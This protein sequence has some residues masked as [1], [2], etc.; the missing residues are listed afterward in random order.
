M[1][2]VQLVASA[3]VVLLG[4]AVA[5][6]FGEPGYVVIVMLFSLPVAAIQAP[7][8]IVLTRQM[9]FSRISIIDVASM[10]VFYT[11]TISWAVAGAGVWAMATGVVCR[12][13]ASSCLFVAIS[14]LGRIRPSLARVR[15]LM[16][17]IRFG[18]VFQLS[19]IAQ[20]SLAQA[21]NFAVGLILGV[22][23]LG[24][25]SLAS[26]LIQLPLVLFQSVW[27]VS[28]PTMS[29]VI[30]SGRDAA[31]V[32]ERVS[33]LAAV[34]AALVLAPFA[35]CAPG[36]V[37]A[38]FGDSWH[39]AGLLVALICIGLLL[40][41]P[42][43]A[44]VTGTLYAAG[45]ARLVLRATVIAGTIAIL[46]SIALMPPLGV[47]GIGVASVVR[48]SLEAM[49]LAHAVRLS[50]GARVAPQVASPVFI[51]LVAGGL[52]VGVDVAMGSTLAGGL[53][54]PVVGLSAAA[55]GLMLVRREDLLAALGV[56][57]DAV[58]NARTRL[59]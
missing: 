38:L 7:G 14:G 58:S 9:R 33:R 47:Y 10:L 6:P 31:P 2:G 36:L 48:A 40:L 26:R 28:F 19:W 11:W 42:V 16:P 32:V 18:I 27:H 37:P 44:A 29:H 53:I 51:G 45:D 5:S 55:V 56:A 22:G 49:I 25:Y 57:R 3:A 23:P 15:E 34:V 35:A 17:T 59:A 30:G 4:A 41:G 50:R 12:T 21:A 13:I 52:G 43:S 46:V 24:V 39:D 20:V 1:T 8:R 54:G